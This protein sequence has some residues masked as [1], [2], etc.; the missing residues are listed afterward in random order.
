MRACGATGWP[1]C[2]EYARDKS[3]ALRMVIIIQRRLCDLRLLVGLFLA[4]QYRGLPLT[5]KG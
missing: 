5:A 3:S 2:S 4:E 1:K